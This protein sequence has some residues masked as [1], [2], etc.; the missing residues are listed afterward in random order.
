M[1][2]F[3]NVIDEKAAY[4]TTQNTELDRACVVVI[5][6]CVGLGGYC[7]VW[8]V[9]GGHCV[10]CAMRYVGSSTTPRFLPEARLDFHAV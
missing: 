4:E 8:W 7:V 2:K 10:R 3:E 6:W 9:L 5:I 1:H